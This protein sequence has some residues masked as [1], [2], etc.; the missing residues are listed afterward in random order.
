MSGIQRIRQCLNT[1]DHRQCLE[2][3]GSVSEYR[4]S[5]TVSG[6]QRITVGS[7][8][9]SGIQRITDSVGIQRV[10]VGSQTVS[11]IQRITVGSQRVNS[12]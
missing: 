5:Q 1:E 12:Q 8:T 7:Q 3:R 11:G 4:G 10:T 2:Y 6:I 9:M